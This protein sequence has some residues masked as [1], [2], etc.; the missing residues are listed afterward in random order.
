M[1]FFLNEISFNY[2]STGSSEQHPFDQ[3]LWWSRFYS[4]VKI[5][6]EVNS[7]TKNIVPNYSK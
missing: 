2:K 6:S 5:Q 1:C 4:I 3:N 7:L